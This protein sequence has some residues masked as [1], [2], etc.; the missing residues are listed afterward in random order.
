MTIKLDTG[1]GEHFTKVSEQA[2]SIAQERE[3]TVEFEFNGVKCLVDKT[4][5]LHHIYRDYCNAH[6]MEWKEVGPNCVYEYDSAT[7]Q[8]LANRKKQSEERQEKQRQEW[9]AKDKAQREAFEEAT[10]GIELDLSDIEGWKKS[11]E[12]NSDGYGGAAM[13]YAEGW[14]KL[15]QIEVS[16]GKTI[17]WC[18]GYTQDGLGFLGISG[19]QF[20]CA[21]G[22]LS[23]TWKH[24]E[25]LRKYHN[26]K[27]GVPEDK[28]GVVNPAILKIG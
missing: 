21:V 13:D 27:Y 22:I 11:R 9:D 14:G 24:G 12:A 5:D 2:Q 3:V 1:L 10:K 4:T 6:M 23:Q 25:E 28:E 7:L 15:M 8:E 17:E 26:K 16:K 19:F 18:Y 20:G